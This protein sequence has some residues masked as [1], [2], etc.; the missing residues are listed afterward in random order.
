LSPP[1]ILIPHWLF[2]HHKGHRGIAQAMEIT[3]PGGRASVS[4][5]GSLIG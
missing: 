1:I 5:R 4:S 3:H 2:F